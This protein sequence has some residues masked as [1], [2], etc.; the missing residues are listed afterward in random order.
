MSNAQSSASRAE[1]DRR[2]SPRI[3]VEVWVEQSTPREVYFQ[4]GA[5]LSAGGIFLERTIPQEVGTRVNLRFEL[6]GEPRP[7]DLR[8][9]IVSAGGGPDQL[10]M[11]VKFVDLDPAEAARLEAYV[12]RTAKER[13]HEP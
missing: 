8:G 7:F 9:E 11:G 1:T 10:G 6:P 12:A 4:R 2:R 3:R 13:R 5:N